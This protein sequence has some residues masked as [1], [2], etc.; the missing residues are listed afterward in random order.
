MKQFVF[1]AVLLAG[2]VA[3]FGNTGYGIRLGEFTL[4]FSQDRQK[5]LDATTRFLEDVKFKDFTHA[6]TFHTEED[7]KK[8]NIP[9]L[10]E[11]KFLTKP[12][13]L[14]V[15][16]FEV[17]RIDIS[18]SGD[19]AKALTRTTMKH[20]NS[21]QL[22]DGKEDVRNLDII[23]YWKRIDGRWYMDLSSSL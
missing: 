12:E 11:E 1:F 17:L 15:R 18:S 22:R 8:K 9:Q 16:A 7:R 5:V 13:F 4:A 6:A 19:R 23:W 3:Y 2:A 21:E 14:D 20:L 10:I